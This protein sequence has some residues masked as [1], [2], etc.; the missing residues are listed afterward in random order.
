MCKLSSSKTLS[1]PFV[2]FPTHLLLQSVEAVL[3]KQK[4]NMAVKE[5]KQAIVTHKRRCKAPQEGIGL[6]QLPHDI[7]V[8]IFGFLDMQSLVSAGLV[9]RSWYLAASDNQ[10]W[11]L[12][13]A[14]LYGSSV[15]EH[16]IRLVE[17]GKNTLLKEPVDTR[18]SIEWKD[19]VKRAY[20]GALSKILASSRGYCQRCK[21][22]VWLINLK[23]PNARCRMMSEVQDIRP[24]T[25]SQAAEYVLDDS[26]FITFSSDSDSDDEEILGG[27]YRLWSFPKHIK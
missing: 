6:P 27:F 22:V 5:F 25:A 3:P 12:Q 4:R 11:E 15:K 26:L 10:L 20:T 19:V 16:P 23:C 21:C 14:V 7:L 13:H 8:H 9:C 24:V 1:L 18:S 2:S 17:D